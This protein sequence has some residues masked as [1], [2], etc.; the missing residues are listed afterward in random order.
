MV[1]QVGENIS[2]DEN[3]RIR[4]LDVDKYNTTKTLQEECGNFSQK[5]QQLDGMVKTYLEA[6]DQQAKQIELEK[7]KAVGLRNAVATLAEDRKRK[8][9]EVERLLADKQQQL[10]R[11]LAEEQSLLRVKHEQDMLITKVTDS[12]C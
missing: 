6:V 2:F 7:L 10:E 12:S 4:V 11:L 1:G 9:K 8:E 5:I 3:Y